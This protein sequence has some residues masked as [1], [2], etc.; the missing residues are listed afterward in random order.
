[1]PAPLLPAG[2]DDLL[3]SHM[4]SILQAFSAQQVALPGGSLVG[5]RTERDRMAAPDSK[6]LESGPIV[7]LYATLYNPD[8]GT[9]RDTQEGKVTVQCDMYTASLES[10][11]GGGDKA[12][13]ARL[14]YLKDQVRAALYA[15]SATD[16][17]FSAGSAHLDPSP[18]FQMTPQPVGSELW[19]CA[20]SWTFEVAYSFTAQDL[21]MIDLT[22]VNVTVDKEISQS[23]YSTRWAGLYNV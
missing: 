14:Y 19:I 10:L 8:K 21:D 18:R 7:S 11:T 1:M 9:T 23:P 2:F 17:G 16:L 22:Q 5:F 15:K 13:M 20:G 12:A 6:E 3:L 4:V